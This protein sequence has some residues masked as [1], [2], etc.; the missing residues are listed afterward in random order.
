MDAEQMR[1]RGAPFTDRSWALLRGYLLKFNK[2]ATAT[3]AKRGEGKGNVVCDPKAKV[4][5]AL[6]EISEAGLLKLDDRE[7]GYY[8]VELWVEGKD[9]TGREA[10]VYIAHPDMV[11]EGLKPTCEYL[12]RYLA[13]RDL[14]SEEYCEMLAMVETL[15]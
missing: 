7:K 10:W 15:D 9:G 12:H 11:R 4:E 8:R 1:K 5:G 3:E 6:Y 2:R 14:L 13:G